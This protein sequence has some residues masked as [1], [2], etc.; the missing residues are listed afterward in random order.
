MP[1]ASCEIYRPFGSPH[2][3]PAC[4]HFRRFTL[5]LDV[6]EIFKPIIVDRLIFTLLEKD[7]RKGQLR[8][9]TEG[10]M[11]K[12]RT[13]SVLRKP[14]EKLKTTINH[15]DI[16]RPVSYRRLIRLSYTN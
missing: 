15:E 5:N 6:A 13:K 11:L 16:G 10:I 14:V 8:S 9:N 1:L 2:R 12:K 3:L 4:N 7:D